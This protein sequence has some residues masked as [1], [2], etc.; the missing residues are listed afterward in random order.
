MLPWLPDWPESEAESTLLSRTFPATPHHPRTATPQLTCRCQ[1]QPGGQKHSSDCS[2]L[3]HII[4]FPSPIPYFP[5]PPSCPPTHPP[6]CGGGVWFLHGHHTASPHVQW[7]GGE[8]GIQRCVA[9]TLQLT[10]LNT[11]WEQGER[12]REGGREEGIEGGIIS[13]RN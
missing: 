13:H 4:P 8:R 10:P 3:E 5:L 9:Y 6:L 11:G 12:E 2:K 7:H 1:E